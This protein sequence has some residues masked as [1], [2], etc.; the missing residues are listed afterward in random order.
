MKGAIMSSTRTMKCR[1]LFAS[2]PGL[3]AGLLL[4]IL[5]IPLSAQP[6]RTSHPGRGFGLGYD[7][8]HEVTLNG[9]VQ[10]VITRHVLGTPAGMHLLIAGPQGTVDAHVGPF[11]TKDTREALR[12]GLPIQIVG[13]TE[14]LHGKQYLLARQLIF[15]GRMVTVR[16]E[17]GFL[18]QP[19]SARR[20]AARA[21]RVKSGPKGG[22]R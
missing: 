8:A 3:L 22:A 2:L 20:A 14:K 7:A 6:V 21:K 17:R 16:S 10:E 1:P 19:Y 15:G 12:T 18:L 4:T 13:A 5:T 9:T 11:L